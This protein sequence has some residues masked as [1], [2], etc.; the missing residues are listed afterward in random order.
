MREGY[1]NSKYF[2]G[3]I[4][5]RRKTNHINSLQDSH[6]SKVEW[7]SSLEHLM[8]EYFKNLFVATNTDWNRVIN[9]M[10]SKVTLAKNDLL[11][12]EVDEKEVKSAILICTQ[13]N[14]ETQMV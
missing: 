10:S 9:C 7:G 4:K 12:E 8:D 3:A 2:H 1:Q 5:N 13:T 6:G 11:L 14:L